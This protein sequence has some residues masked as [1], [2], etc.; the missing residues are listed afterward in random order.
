[1]GLSVALG[2]NRLEVFD[3]H[4]AGKTTERLSRGTAEALYLALR[5]GLISQ[6]GDVGPGLPLLMDDVLVNLDP[7]RRRGAAVAV[8][9]LARERQIVLFTCHPDTATLLG[10]IAPDHTRITLDRC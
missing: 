7:E 4:A 1:M 2:S 8:A 6:L 5:L 3:E 9:D 10:E